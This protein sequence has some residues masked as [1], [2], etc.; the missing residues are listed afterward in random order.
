MKGPVK[1]SISAFLVD[2]NICYVET[3]GTESGIHP[4]IGTHKNIALQ[5]AVQ[6]E[7][8]S[9]KKVCHQK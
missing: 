8:Y 7:R 9:S 4:Y 6:L 5:Q 1:L 3:N 2:R